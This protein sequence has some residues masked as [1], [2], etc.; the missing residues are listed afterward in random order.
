MRV[1]I[2]KKSPKFEVFTGSLWCFGIIKKINMTLKFGPY[3]IL[4]RDFK[5]KIA[6]HMRFSRAG[7]FW[8]LEA[9]KVDKIC[10]H[11]TNLC[12]ADCLK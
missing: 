3:A 9:V 11:F 1:I 8:P 12:G 2:L 7:I 6:F 5:N 10:N 4:Y